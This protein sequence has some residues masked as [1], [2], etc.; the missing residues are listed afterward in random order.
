VNDLPKIENP[1]Q[2]FPDYYPLDQ[3]LLVTGTAALARY[4]LKRKKKDG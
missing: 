3:V 1:K 2:I 4:E